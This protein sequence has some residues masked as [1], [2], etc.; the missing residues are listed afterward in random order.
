VL[1]LWTQAPRAP[2]DE[3]AI[4][5]LPQGVVLPARQGKPDRAVKGVAINV[6]VSTGTASLDITG[7]TFHQKSKDTL[8]CGATKSYTL[9]CAVVGGSVETHR[10]AFAGLTTDDMPSGKMRELR[11]DE[12]EM[13]YAASSISCDMVT[14]TYVYDSAFAHFT[15][16]YNCSITGSCYRFSC[17]GS[18][19]RVRIIPSGYLNY[20]I[21]CTLWKLSYWLG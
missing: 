13:L 4:C 8:V 20:L 9:N 18:I 1:P 16:G 5:Q 14:C 7:G 19:L 17:R 15:S 6:P 10:E 11:P 3:A 2:L 12:V 21:G